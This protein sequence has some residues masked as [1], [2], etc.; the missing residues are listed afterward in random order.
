MSDPA[1]DRRIAFQ[2]P[3]LIALARVAFLENLGAC[4]RHY[5]Q[6]MFP[7]RWPSAN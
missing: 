7:G 3:G 1:E 2:Q 5:V 6:R 4:A